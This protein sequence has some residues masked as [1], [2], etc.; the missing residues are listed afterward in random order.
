M[1][2]LDHKLRAYNFVDNFRVRRPCVYFDIVGTN[3]LQ[4]LH[5]PEEFTIKPHWGHSNCGVF[6]VKKRYIDAKTK[7]FD[8]I[9]EKHYSLD[10]LSRTILTEINNQN[11]LNR[12]KGRKPVH[13]YNADDVPVFIEESIG[14]SNLNSNHVQDMRLYCFRGG[15]PLIM[16]RDMSFGPNPLDWK[17]NFFDG[18]LNLLG[19]VKFKDRHMESLLPIAPTDTIR[20]MIRTADLLSQNIHLPFVRIDYHVSYEECVFGEFTIIPGGD[21]EFDKTTDELLGEK[22]VASDVFPD[23][24]IYK[25]HYKLD[26]IVPE[27]FLV[28]SP[29]LSPSEPRQ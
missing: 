22:Y 21:F 6:V 3:C 20:Q 14:Q 9:R 11:N 2:A 28:R 12:R 23:P 29:A 19:P 24:L 4:H 7:Y 16:L 26:E 17:F 10:D 18:C 5:L 25:E 8:N 1:N 13:Q 27:A 15:I